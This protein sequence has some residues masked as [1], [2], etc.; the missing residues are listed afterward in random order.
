MGVEAAMGQARIL[1]DV[2]DAGAA[3]SAA[4][5]GAR[6][7]VHDALVG[8]FLAAGVRSSLGSGSHMTLIIYPTTVKRKWAIAGCEQPAAGVHRR[9]RSAPAHWRALRH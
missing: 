2:G 5:D 4:A 9:R 8:R 6:G 7:G 3:V 1:H